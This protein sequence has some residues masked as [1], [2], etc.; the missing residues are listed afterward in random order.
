MSQHTQCPNCSQ[1]LEVFFA[2]DVEGPE[3]VSVIVCQPEPEPP[4]TISKRLV[5]S[6]PVDPTL[7]SPATAQVLANGS[8]VGPWREMAGTA[9][10]WHVGL[11]EDFGES[12]TVT[13]ESDTSYLFSG[14]P[15]GTEL[16][17]ETQNAKAQ[18]IGITTEVLAEGDW[19][20]ICPVVQ[21]TLTDA[22]N[23]GFW[24]VDY[25]AAEVP[26]NASEADFNAA[27]NTQHNRTVVVT[28]PADFTFRVE[29]TDPA[30]YT[31]QVDMQNVSSILRK[32]VVFSFED[33]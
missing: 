24:R 28:Y 10:E 7:P 31:V 9:P 26:Y 14:L 33:A 25:N 1:C 2:D 6:A 21:Y 13:K 29:F 11:Q 17:I 20:S 12:V 30:P 23:E 19:V 16:S 22:P 27:I 8:P 18:A 15:D 4:A 5:L 32:P 3:I